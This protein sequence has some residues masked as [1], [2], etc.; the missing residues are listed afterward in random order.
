MDKDQQIKNLTAQVEKLVLLVEKLTQTVAKL[1]KENMELKERLAHYENSKN[2]RNSSIPPSKDENRPLKTKSLREKS[3]KRIG[4]QHGHKGS[5]LQMSE[6][7]DHIIDHLPCY[8]GKCGS[9]LSNLPYCLMGQRQVVDIPPI[10]PEYTEHRIYQKRCACGHD[11]CSTYP[12]EAIAT[13]SYGPGV[14]SLVGYLHTRQYLPF[15]RMKELFNDVLNLS[16]SE[17]GLHCMMN[18]LTK[19]ATPIYEQLRTRITESKVVGADETGAKMNG[20][21]IW[22]WTWQNTKTTFI[23][24]SPNRG[25]DTIKENF[26]DGFPNTILVSDC[27]KSHFQPK[28]LQHQLCIAH[29]LRELNYFQECY[30]SD[31]AKK[32]KTIFMRGLDIKTKMKP[33][34][35][36]NHHPPRELIEKCM[37]ELLSEIT[38][39][40]HKEVTTFRKRMTKYRNHIFTYLYHPEVPSDNN[41]SERAIRNV[42]VKQKISGQFKSMEGANR[43]AIL[44]SITDTAIKNG[45]NVLNSLLCVAQL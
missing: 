21:K 10:K 17:G 5:T 15:M 33:S 4:G 19:K 43:F 11:T 30:K 22:I 44:R 45:Q 31:W 23:A 18:R 40:K 24:A 28:A 32:C 26:P 35:Y 25:Y 6:N 37:D 20:K 34:D 42:K 12:S 27:W 36:K 8:C 14:E 1:T 13:V 9:D 39:A 7:P 3:Q 38:D 29:L 2:S 16:I 41:G